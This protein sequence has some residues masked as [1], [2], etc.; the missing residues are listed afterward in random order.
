MAGCRIVF[1]VAKDGDETRLALVL[2]GPQCEDE[3]LHAAL[4]KEWSRDLRAIQSWLDID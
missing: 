2:S 4:D 3:E 1:Q